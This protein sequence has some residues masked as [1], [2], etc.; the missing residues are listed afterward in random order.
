MNLFFYPLEKVR[1]GKVVSS[2]EEL[3]YAQSP[4]G[5]EML[6]HAGHKYVIVKDYKNGTKTW[7]CNGLIKY[8]CKA[9]ARTLGG[10]CF[11]S[12]EHNHPR[13]TFPVQVVKVKK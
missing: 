10:L 2:K 4:K 11:L 5:R 6:L 13:E 12:K 8:Q 3:V 1:R 7:R 9:V